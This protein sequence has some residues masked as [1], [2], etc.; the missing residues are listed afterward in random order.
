M[1]MGG[2][3]EV[4]GWTMSFGRLRSEDTRDTFP[5][6]QGAGVRLNVAVFLPVSIS[7][8]F[9]LILHHSVRQF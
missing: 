1:C 5:P 3:A 9:S 6:S 2:G 8:L 7:P 4:G